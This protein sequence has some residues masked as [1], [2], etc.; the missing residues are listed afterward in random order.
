MHVQSITVEQLAKRLQQEPEQI[1]LLDVREPHEVE[2]CSLANCVH[3]P[4][5]QIP[6]RQHEL[7]DE[8]DIVVYCHHGIRSFSV[9]AFLLQAGFDESRIYNLTGGIDHWAQVIDHNMQQY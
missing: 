7:P 1:L 5:N 9:A 6:I 8:Q 4:M 2:I 3:I